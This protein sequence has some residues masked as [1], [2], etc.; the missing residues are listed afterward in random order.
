M[1]SLHTVMRWLDEDRDGELRRQYARGREALA[2]HYGEAV[3]EIADDLTDDANSRRVR[4][5]ARKWAASKLYPKRYGDKVENTLVG[6]E[7][8]PILIATG[9]VRAGE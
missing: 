2:D 8:G 3:V 1:P 9:V 7:G 4:M 6:N 5:D